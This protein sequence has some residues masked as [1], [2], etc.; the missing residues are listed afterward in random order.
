MPIKP[1]EKE[2]TILVPAWRLRQIYIALLDALERLP[3]SVL[4]LADCIKFM[5]KE[6]DFYREINDLKYISC[7]NLKINAENENGRT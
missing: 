4:N 3:N 6:Y 2:L 7:R 1:S 5:E